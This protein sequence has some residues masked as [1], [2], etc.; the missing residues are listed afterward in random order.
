MDQA[1]VDKLR[2]ECVEL[3]KKMKEAKQRRK[4]RLGA[5]Q[6]TQPTGEDASQQSQNAGKATSNADQQAKGAREPSQQPESSETGNAKQRKVQRNARARFDSAQ[7][8]LSRHTAALATSNSTREDLKSDHPLTVLEKRG[9]PLQDPTRDG[10]TSVRSMNSSAQRRQ[11][12]TFSRGSEFHSP[13]SA[14]GSTV[15]DEASVRSNASMISSVRPCTVSRGSPAQSVQMRSVDSGSPEIATGNEERRSEESGSDNGLQRRVQAIKAGFDENIKRQ[16]LSSDQDVGV[17]ITTSGNVARPSPTKSE[18]KTP[19]HAHVLPPLEHLPPITLSSPRPSTHESEREPSDPEEGLIEA[20]PAAAND[21]TPRVEDD[22]PSK[23]RPWLKISSWV[24]AWLLLFTLLAVLLG[25]QFKHDLDLAHDQATS[26]KTTEHAT[27]RERTWKP[28]E[29]TQ[30]FVYTLTWP[31]D[32]SDPPRSL[33]N[34]TIRQLKT[35]GSHTQVANDTWVVD[36][37]ALTRLSL[38]KLSVDLKVEAKHGVD[39]DALCPVYVPVSSARSQRF[40]KYGTTVLRTLLTCMVFLPI[41]L[42]CQF[43][44]RKISHLGTG[45]WAGEVATAL[46]VLLALGVAAGV[47]LGV[48]VGIWEVVEVLYG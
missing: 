1:V 30:E 10:T 26:L 42:A 27:A 2:R 44:A 13:S 41:W 39:V 7:Q 23:Q 5:S 29:H 11:Y 47:V 8:S 31:Q 28:F 22:A 20:P 19:E 48:Q 21:E 33:R 18:N 3:D 38:T 14:P 9:L 45:P 6:S 43:L 34:M 46:S 25:R 36:L 35:F 17:A 40:E 12:A 37:F 32:P 15:L 4:A 16:A 24:I